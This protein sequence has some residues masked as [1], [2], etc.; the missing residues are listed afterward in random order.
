MQKKEILNHLAAGIEKQVPNVWDE[1]YNKVHNVKDNMSKIDT[2]YENIYCIKTKKNRLGRMA[3][4]AACIVIIAIL[5]FSPVPAHVETEIAK[6]LGFLYNDKGINNAINKG[7]GQ[8]IN[9]SCTD[10]GITVSIDGIISDDNRTAILLTIQGDTEKLKYATIDRIEITD[11]NGNIISNGGIMRYSYDN[12]KSSRKI[13]YSI[14]SLNNYVGDSINIKINKINI[15]Y[16]EPIDID[17]GIRLDDKD[18][19]NASINLEDKI[20][21]LKSFIIKNY[22]KDKDVARIDI[23]YKIEEDGINDMIF[24]KL[25]Y[26]KNQEVQVIDYQI[27]PSEYIDDGDNI[28]IKQ[29]SKKIA[30]YR[31]TAQYKVN[32]LNLTSNDVRIVAQY[33]DNSNYNSI[34]GNWAFN[35]T[36]QKNLANNSTLKIKANKKFSFNNHIYKI[37][38]VV[39]SPSETRVYIETSDI[40]PAIDTK[41]IILKNNKNE[42]LRC[43]QYFKDSEG[44]QVYSFNPVLEYEDVIFQISDT[45]CVPISK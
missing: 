30:G 2:A 17:T 36:L 7:L 9:K 43:I 38:H 14:D 40:V 6:I 41:D 4:A 20:P 18:I 10:K 8:I 37:K 45:V 12:N 13:I 21:F 44:F 24:F 35:L 42:I 29:I 31:V 28:N 3:V 23:E 32:D 1:I 19:V 34:N 27:V 33:Y 11:K 22:E 26:G 39:F 25:F 16:Y 5:A 15:N